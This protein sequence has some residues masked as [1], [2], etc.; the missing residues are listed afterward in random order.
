MNQHSPP[1]QDLGDPLATHAAPLIH[2]GFPKA[3]SSWMQKHLF[4]P[5]C[6][7]V[8]VLDPLTCQLSVINP[9]PFAFSPGAAHE[10]MRAALATVTQEGIVPVITSEALAGNM[11]C[12]G[13]NGKELADRLHTLAPKGRILLMVREQR[14]LIRSLYKSW[15]AWGMPHSIDRLLEPL[16]PELS[17]QFNLDYLRFDQR[18][19]YYQ[20]LFGQDRVQVLP[21]EAF[22]KTPFI[23]LR[24]IHD[25]AGAAGSTRSALDKLPVRARVNRGE[26]LAWLYWLRLQ[27]R[28][29]LSTPFNYNGL[30]PATNERLMQ[31]LA[32]SKK[33]PLP[34]FTDHW[35]EDRFQATVAEKTRG[36]FAASNRRLA[37][38][39]GLDLAAHGYEL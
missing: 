38:L 5:G 7:F 35:F 23:L 20:G 25:F 14:S 18:V 22:A 19:A 31:R 26:S 17:P 21:Y 27:N 4:Q 34:R 15:I 24:Q 10:H 12:G 9:S 29:L 36:Q 39:T 6:G 28:L 13:F 2:V 11:Y 1:S 33:N 8:K 32:R 37:A 30:R 16:T 3:I